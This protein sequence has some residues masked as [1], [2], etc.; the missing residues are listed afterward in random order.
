MCFNAQGRWRV[1]W[2]TH[3]VLNKS[4]SNRNRNDVKRCSKLNGNHGL[5]ATVTSGSNV[6]FW[7]FYSIFSK[8]SLAIDS[9]ISMHYQV[10]IYDACR[11]FR[12]N[13][14]GIRLS[15]GKPLKCIITQWA[16]PEN[17]HTY[18][19]DS[20]LEVQGQ[21]G[22]FELEFW[23]HGGLLRLE[24]WRHGGFQIWYFQRG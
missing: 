13:E 11:K 8:V 1:S 4:K 14:R 10:M 23:T 15:W 12:E 6:K 21:G 20:F 22:F 3:L 7:V 19:T 17:I 2:R 5:L 16:I 9:C 18:T 24:F